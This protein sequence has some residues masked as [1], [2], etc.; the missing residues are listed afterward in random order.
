MSEYKLTYFDGRARAELIRLVFVASGQKFTDERI[1][2]DE[3][4]FKD[5]KKIKEG[6]KRRTYLKNSF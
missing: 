6:I 2:V 3:W 5:N 1:T 4:F